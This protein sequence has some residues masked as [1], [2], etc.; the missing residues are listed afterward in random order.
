MFRDLGLL[1][2]RLI[3]G[4]IFA[5]HGY[6]KLFGGP[7]KQVPQS[8]ADVLGQGFVNAV[9]NGSPQSFATTVEHVG[10]PQPEMMAWFVAGLEF[11]GGIMVALGI[12][13]RPTALL[14]AAE[15]VEAI[16]RVHLRN[17][18]IGQGG[19]EFALSLLGSCLALVGTGP[20]AISI[21]GEK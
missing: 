20:G 8:V 12:W 6:P 15:M 2:M 11:F 13:T 9:H 14:L 4:G 3:V 17:G 21:E 18:L 5:A 7:N 16:R 19:Y 10:A 1:A